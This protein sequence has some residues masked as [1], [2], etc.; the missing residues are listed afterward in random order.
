MPAVLR[1]LRRFVDAGHVEA[2][3]AIVTMTDDGG[4]SGRLRRD[5]GV[6]PPGDVRNCLVA[7]SAEEELLKGV[8]QH[9]YNGSGE[10]GGHTLGNLMLAALAEQTGS[11]LK[12]VE[13]SSRVLR[14]VGT[15]L[16]STLEDVTLEATF[17]DGSRVVGESRVAA[18]GK[19]IVR[20]ELNPSSAQPTPGILDALQT[21]DLIVLGPGSIYTSILPNVI[22]SGVGAALRQ[23]QAAVVLVANFVGEHGEAV[24]LDVAS[25]VSALEEHAGGRFLDGVLIHEG[26]LPEEVLDRY[27]EEGMALLSP[28]NGLRPELQ[29]LKR[30][31][32]AVSPKLRHDPDATA[33]GVVDLWAAVRSVSEKTAER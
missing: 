19:R 3:T 5:R 26:A 24:G 28:G 6:P 18:V 29:V 7:L 16:P 1:G 25:H 13:V 15:I 33:R 10:L 2:L 23:S 30:S 20:V 12:A 21:A 14:T 17:E 4:S 9:R 11:F 32:A 27:R 31:L 22:V 8:F